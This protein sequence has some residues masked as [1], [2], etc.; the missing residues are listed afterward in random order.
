MEV[1]HP[2]IFKGNVTSFFYPVFDVKMPYRTTSNEANEVAD[3]A[4][5]QQK[6]FFL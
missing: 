5:L 4:I 3:F 2:G 1:G 6:V